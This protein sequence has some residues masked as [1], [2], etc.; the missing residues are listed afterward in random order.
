M[1][2]NMNDENED[3]FLT[4]TSLAYEKYGVYINCIENKTLEINNLGNKDKFIQSLMKV[5]T[6]ENL[7]LKYKFLEKFEILNDGSLKLRSKDKEFNTLNQWK[8]KKIDDSVY[9]LLGIMEKDSSSCKEAFLHYM[10]FV[11]TYMELVNPKSISI[12]DV[13]LSSNNFYNDILSLI[14]EEGPYLSMTVVE[15]NASKKTL[16]KLDFVKSLLD[17]G[18]I[19]NYV[20]LCGTS[21]LDEL[22]DFINNR[23]LK[24]YFTLTDVKKYSVY[25]RGEIISINEYINKLIKEDFDILNKDNVLATWLDAKIIN[26]KNSEAVREKLK[27]CDEK[28]TKLL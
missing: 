1:Y 13:K 7:K 6:L 2:F 5:D 25:R 3:F 22:V 19:E 10:M 11:K 9:D 15:K 21:K 18:V 4:I 27:K 16:Y 20:K 24:K 12:A 8:D 23:T 14:E 28:I 17:L 26:D